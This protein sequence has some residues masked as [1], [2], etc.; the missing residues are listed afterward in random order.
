MTSASPSGASA[1]KTPVY[2]KLVNDNRFIG[3]DAGSSELKLVGPDA[4]SQ[5]QIEDTDNIVEKRL[6][7][8]GGTKAFTREGYLMFRKWYELDDPSL[9]DRQ[10]IYIVYAGPKEF[11]LMEGGDCLSYV[12][13][14]FRRVEC[15]AA[16]INRFKI[17]ENKECAETRGGHM[18]RRHGTHGVHS[19][20]SHQLKQLNR[21]VTAIESGL[22]D[23][24]AY[25]PEGHVAPGSRRRHSWPITPPIPRYAPEPP[26]PLKQPTGSDE[27]PNCDDMIYQYLQQQMRRGGGGADDDYT[28]T[29]EWNESTSH[30]E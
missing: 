9:R 29:T 1:A 13:D 21:K 15:T 22:H 8:A 14:Y 2:F 30:P 26:N 27:G 3:H 25:G 24:D 16:D 5:F 7:T 17:C 18:H 10:N 20:L 23:L 11:V 4:A 6:L 28:T 19:E 12:V